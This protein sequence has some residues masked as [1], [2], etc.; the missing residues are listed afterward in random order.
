MLK[1]I[2]KTL[3]I[4]GGSCAGKSTVSRIL[5]RKYQLPLY[6]VDQ[7]IDED[8][9]KRIDKVAFPCLYELDTKGLQWLF[10]MSEKRFLAFQKASMKEYILLAKE[11]ISKMQPDRCILVN[12]GE[13]A[14]PD[15][16]VDYISTDQAVFFA[17]TER[18]QLEEWNKRDWVREVLKSFPNPELLYSKW[19][20]LDLFQAKYIVAQAKKYG[21]RLLIRDENLTIDDAVHY[22]ETHFELVTMAYK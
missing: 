8:Y 10:N 18:I 22:T 1:D 17:T 12:G 15:V 19:M 11:D 5:A 6:S 9:S 20:A 21:F 13:I 2:E 16:L 7:H 4:C 14:F 3:W